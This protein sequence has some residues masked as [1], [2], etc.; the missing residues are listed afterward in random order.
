MIYLIFLI[1]HLLSSLSFQR[2]R[3]YVFLFAETTIPETASTDKAK[4][5]PAAAKCLTLNIFTTFS[6]FV[7]SF[8]HAYLHLYALRNPAERFFI[9]LSHVFYD[10]VKV[11]RRYL[12]A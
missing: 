11:Q 2:I 6:L 3:P 1:Y 10:T 4:N 8:K 5:K 7:V 9:D 12:F